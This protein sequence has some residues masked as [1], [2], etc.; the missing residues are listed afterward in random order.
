MNIFIRVYDSSDIVSCRGEIISKLADYLLSVTRRDKIP[1]SD[2]VTII[3]RIKGIDSVSVSFISERNESAI[4]NGYYYKNTTKIDQVT[5]TEIVTKD[6]ILVPANTDPNIGLDEFGD[7]KID[8][9]EQ[10]L[11]RGG[12]YDRFNNFYEDGVSTSILSSINIVVKDVIK[13]TIAVQQ[14]IENKSKL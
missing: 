2:I 8:K 14:V 13:T 9:Y 11:F 4:S 10:P 3:E 6:K 1:K 7:I 12:W 5:Q